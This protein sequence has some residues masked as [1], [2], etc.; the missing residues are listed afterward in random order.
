M[1]RKPAE[2]KMPLAIPDSDERDVRDE[3][4][5]AQDIIEILRFL[6]E[7]G[8]CPHK[9]T[10]ALPVGRRSLILGHGGDPRA[11]GVRRR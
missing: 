11:I 7:H 3:I 5:D 6:G 1:K 10:A 4:E 9:S 2:K 8:I